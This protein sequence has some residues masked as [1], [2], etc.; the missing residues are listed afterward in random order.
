MLIELQNEVMQPV[1]WL[2]LSKVVWIDI[3]LSG[4]N[5]LVIAMACR[6]LDPKQR[7]LGMALGAGAA[8][9]LRIACTGVISTLLEY[10]Y[11][12]IVGGLALLYVATKL[13][14]PEKEGGD[15]IKSANRLWSAIR[16]VMV[17][18]T[19]RPPKK[20]SMNS[21]GRSPPRKSTGALAAP[22]PTRPRAWRWPTWTPAP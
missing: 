18:L 2:G 12:K 11:L 10:P 21:A 13:L 9:A 17:W 14:L 8:V 19:S 20:C 7:M 1:F 6:G 5:A 4:D 22:M 16:I 3:L 15:D